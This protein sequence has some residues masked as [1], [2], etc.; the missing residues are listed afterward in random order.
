M[1]KHRT[2]PDGYM[3]V[4]EIAK[5]AGVTVRTM[6][7]YDKEGLLSPQATS[8]GGF[9]LYTDKDMVKLIQILM[10]KQLGFSLAE[11]KER[12]PSLDT[13]AD[14]VNVLTE[15]AAG[16]RK[17]VELLSESL[18][19]IEALKAE[20]EQM[21]AVDFKKFAF[22]LVNLQ[23]KNEQYWMIKYF[24]ND[25]LDKLSS[26]MNTEKAET[27]METLNRLN[28][29]ATTLQ[30]AGEPPD[31]EKGQEL[32][33]A[34]WEILM[35][36]T[37]GDMGLM[38]QLN[39]HAE[40]MSV[41]E[42]S[43]LE[44]SA[45]SNFIQPAMEIYLNNLFLGELGERISSEKGEIFLTA[46]RRMNSEVIKLQNEGEQPGGGKG[47][48]LAKEFWKVLTDITGGDM[49]LIQQLSEHMEKV[50]AFNNQNESYAAVNGFIKS[51]LEIYLSG[52]D[53]T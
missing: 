11:I 48:S 29:E 1:D 49:A 16:I 25:F 31:S 44:L 40:K 24:D 43:R 8:E 22:I 35:D 27:I 2:I 3:R 47:Q 46:M 26:S 39:E 6:Q 9:R 32:A 13:T 51:A 53:I 41:S 28:T 17:K 15:H 18:A 5:K 33:K 19:E 7:Y 12:L 37:G 14:V 38:Q 34:F 21:E 10:M 50:T 23:M 20:I 30:A 52:G 45:A 42:A 4:G 36:I